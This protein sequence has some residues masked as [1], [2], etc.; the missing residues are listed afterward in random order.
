MVA[1]SNPIGSIGPILALPGVREAVQRTRARVAAV[2]PV[3]DGRVFE[4]L[5]SQP[6]EVLRRHLALLMRELGRKLTKGPIGRRQR[7]LP[8]VAGNGMHE[9]IG[10][11]R[12]PDDFSDLYPEVVRVRLGSV[13][14]AHLGRHHRGQHLSLDSGE[15]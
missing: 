5:G 7:G 15:W 11:F 4:S 1:P 6:L 2:S 10:L 8:P 14:A 3:V 12:I 9:G 13:M